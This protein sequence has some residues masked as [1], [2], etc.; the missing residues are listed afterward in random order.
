MD[1]VTHEVLDHLNLGILIVDEKLKILFQNRFMLRFIKR[2]SEDRKCGSLPELI[3]GFNSPYFQI[4]LMDAL[5]QGHSLFFSAA[6]HEKLIDSREKYNIR[7]TRFME[8]DQKRLLLEFTEVTDSFE[9][10]RQLRESISQLRLLNQE[11]KQKEKAIQSLAYYDQLTG[12]ANRALFYE[13]AEKFLRAAERNHEVL[14][15]MFIDVDNFK[16]INDTYGHEAGDKVLVQVAGILTAATRRNDVVARYGGDEFLILLPQINAPD[17]YKI[18]VSKILQAK[19]DAIVCNGISVEICLS[20]GV[21]FYPQDGDS[22]DQLIVKADRAMYIA[23]KQE[24]DNWYY[25][26][27]NI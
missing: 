6:M 11:L 3:P 12:V 2:H 21:S 15:L 10:I 7:V 18:V 23:K 9:R 8:E 17:N 27:E 14:G 4:S 1:T 26:A 19:R 25:P 24:G 13:L 22:I 20:V 16:Q 5:E